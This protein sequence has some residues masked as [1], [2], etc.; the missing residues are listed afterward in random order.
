MQDIRLSSCCEYKHKPGHI[1]GG[2]NGHFQFV[3]VEG[4]A[5][6]Y[7]CQIA[8]THKG[9]KSKHR[10]S[11]GNEEDERNKTFLTEASGIFL[12]L[13]IVNKIKAKHTKLE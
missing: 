7:R 10:A 4:A 2:K 5:P 13:A 3:M 1:L 12:S 9:Y 6:C 11:R 8:S